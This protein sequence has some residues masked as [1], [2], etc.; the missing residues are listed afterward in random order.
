MPACPYCGSRDAKARVVAEGTDQPFRF[1]GVCGVVFKSFDPTQHQTLAQNQYNFGSWGD[2]FEAHLKSHGVRIEGL[3]GVAAEAQAFSADSRYLDIGAGTGV[4]VHV[5]RRMLAPAVPAITACEP[6]GDLA[7]SLAQKFQDVTVVCGD[8]ESLNESDADI[9]RFDVIFCFGVDYLFRDFDRSIAQ[10]KNLLAP[11]GRVIF[12]RNV[13][14]DMPCYFGGKSIET[15]AQLVEPNPMISTYLF[16]EQYAEW[17]GRH[18]DIRLNRTITEYYNLGTRS[19]PSSGRLSLIDAIP[20]KG[21][22][23][24]PVLLADRGRAHLAKLGAALEAP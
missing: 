5:L 7:I 16:A 11:G 19:A 15:L 12:N 20:G 3:L 1:C 24:A 2:T 9:G 8:L 18:L 10:L 4:L 22:P 6:V 14:L 21:R 13:F 23:A 17:I